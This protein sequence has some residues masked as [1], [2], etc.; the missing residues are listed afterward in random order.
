MFKIGP[1]V[2]T[3]RRGAE[4]GGIRESRKREAELLQEAERAKRGVVLVRIGYAKETFVHHVFT[5]E[6]R[7]EPLKTMTIYEYLSKFFTEEAF[8]HVMLYPCT[9]DA[10]K[11]TEDPNNVVDITNIPP[12]SRHLSFHVPLLSPLLPKGGEEIPEEEKGFMRR[13]VSI[14]IKEMKKRMASDF[15][16]SI[17]PVTTSCG[18]VFSNRTYSMEIVFL[19]N[20]SR[21]S[22]R[23]LFNYDGNG[24]LTEGQIDDLKMILSRD[25][26]MS[27]SGDY[28]QDL[29]GDKEQVSTF[30]SPHDVLAALFTP[31]SKRAIARTLVEGRD[32]IVDMLPKGRKVRNFGE[33]REIS[34]YARKAFIFFA[35]IKFP[36]DYDR[37]RKSLATRIPFPMGSTMKYSMI[38]MFVPVVVTMNHVVEV[39]L[40]Q[41]VPDRELKYDTNQWYSDRLSFPTRIAGFDTMASD[42]KKIRQG[43]SVEGHSRR[44]TVTLWIRV[45]I[46]LETPSVDGIIPHRD[47]SVAELLRDFQTPKFGFE[48]AK[49]IFTFDKI[50]IERPVV[51]E[52]KPDFRVKNILRDSGFRLEDIMKRNGY[53]GEAEMFDDFYYE[54]EDKMEDRELKLANELFAMK[55][56]DPVRKSFSDDEIRRWLFSVFRLEHMVDGTKP[57]SEGGYPLFKYEYTEAGEEERRT[58]SD[59]SN[60][61]ITFWEYLEYWEKHK[62][63]DTT[64]L[65]EYVLRDYESQW[66][67]SYMWQTLMED[68]PTIN[69]ISLA[70]G[71]VEEYHTPPTPPVQGEPSLKWTSTMEERPFKVVFLFNL[72]DDS[73]QRIFNFEGNPWNS[74]SEEK[75]NFVRELLAYNE[76]LDEHEFFLVDVSKPYQTFP[77]SYSPRDMLAE[78]LL[79][80]KEGKEEAL[81]EEGKGLV[82]YINSVGSFDP[83]EFPVEHVAAFLREVFITYVKSKFLEEYFSGPSLPSLPDG[84]RIS[85]SMINMFIPVS[86]RLSDFVEVEPGERGNTYNTRTWRTD[87]SSFVRRLKVFDNLSEE[88]SK[89]H[90][91]T[92]NRFVKEVEGH[93]TGKTIVLWIRVEIDLEVEQNGILPYRDL[94]VED[95]LRDFVVPEKSDSGPVVFVPDKLKAEQPTERERLNYIS[96]SGIMENN[97]IDTLETIREGSFRGLITDASE[98][99]DYVKYRELKLT[100]ELY[101]MK[102]ANPVKGYF[103]QEVLSRL[104]IT[105][106][107]LKRATYPP[108]SVMNIDNVYSIFKFEYTEAGEKERRASSDNAA[109][110]ISFWKYLEFFESYK[111]IASDYAIEEFV[112]DDYDMR[113]VNSRMLDTLKEGADNIH[114]A[115]I[116]DIKALPSSPTM[117][118]GESQPSGGGSHWSQWI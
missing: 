85:Y 87:W 46:D 48:D 34:S 79:S 110:V 66:A 96:V 53:T 47:L 52:R 112:L 90:D 7:F 107:R 61:R 20:L 32:N 81:K 8:K 5:W 62:A 29:T 42:I 17:G 91:Y 13:L 75:V 114:M 16:P 19:F 2:P 57:I 118:I 59:K 10:F 11:T 23:Y 68:V 15:I 88:V 101:S 12:E 80:N 82:E 86:V 108:K 9:E 28:L 54:T 89:I 40:F 64:H 95:L 113:W 111:E 56:A 102:Y 97:D 98:A 4:G 58:L 36:K 51:G 21:F 109:P 65:K 25:E 67:N 41:E 69:N 35:G 22:L 73:L 37:S 44:R 27:P 49:P 70:K 33:A 31:P 94:S 93:A 24:A 30:Y 103:P 116:E 43:K 3:R 6:E 50:K 100:N 76:I 78:L 26:G 71:T 55:Y 83:E 45:E 1:K 60:P 117:T 99:Y 92:N 74:L 84:S 77:M 104:L 106:F 39:D 38:N 72:S 105:V 18:Y 115:S 63:N 14:R